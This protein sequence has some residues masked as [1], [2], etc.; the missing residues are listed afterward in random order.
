MYLNNNKNDLI[1]NYTDARKKSF[2]K[3]EDSDE[4][5]FFKNIRPLLVLMKICGLFPADMD[6]NVLNKG[7]YKRAN[8]YINTR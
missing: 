4:I 3:D 7:T 1:S 2:I 5:L 8:A 6:H